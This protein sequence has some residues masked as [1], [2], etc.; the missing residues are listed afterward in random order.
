MGSISVDAGTFKW[1]AD[2][3]QTGTYKSYYDLNKDNNNDI[4]TRGTTTN[5][6][7]GVDSGDRVL[8]FST[9]LGM[10]GEWTLVKD[11]SVLFRLATQFDWLGSQA[12]GVEMTSYAGS[13][14][15]RRHNVVNDLPFYLNKLYVKFDDF[16][17]FPINFKFGRQNIWLGKGFVLGNRLFGAGPTIYASG[18]APSGSNNTTAKNGQINLATAGNLPLSNLASNG[19]YHAPETSDWTGFDAF[20]GNVHLMNSKLNFDFGYALVSGALSEMTGGH[21]SNGATTRELGTDDDEHLFFFNAGYKEMNK[22]NAE[23]Y[24][25]FNYDKEPV[26]DV[27]DNP[28]TS[29]KGTDKIFTYGVRADADWGKGMANL[30]NVNTFAEL[31]YQLGDLG[32]FSPGAAVGR[33]RSAFAFNLGSEFKLDTTYSPWFSLEGV[34]FSGMQ[35]SKIE[36]N[37]NGGTPAAGNIFVGADEKWQVWDPQFRGR[38]FT[39]IM[40]FIDS[41][42]LTDTLAPDGGANTTAGRIDAG[43]TNRWIAVA[44][45]GLQPMS[46]T[47][48]GLAFAY[49]QAHQPPSVGAEK[50]LGF[51]VDW[52]LSYKMSTATTWWFD[53][54]IFLPG[55]YYEMPADAVGSTGKE[56]AWLLRTGFKLDLG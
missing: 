25:L 49:S 29:E 13:N 2:A 45:A 56:S 22:W 43:F 9:L 4:A 16:G 12:G 31:A 23:S 18:Y 53:G 5:Y 44:K 14:Q 10:N 51:E 26:T 36:T 27:N 47:N 34:F 41:V 38:F 50:D 35:P 33:Q 55:G 3:T 40:D 48:F 52:D 42:Y 19:S 21:R 11:T 20:T 37:D 30:S 32:A 6:A 54:G 7:Q 8:F 39:K 1:S 24:L 17:G 46:K 15:D 28:A